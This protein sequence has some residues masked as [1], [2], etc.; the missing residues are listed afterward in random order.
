MAELSKQDGQCRGDNRRP[1]EA[2]ADRNLRDGLI[3]ALR[4]DIC[5]MPPEDKAT[6]E[7]IKFLRFVEKK[8]GDY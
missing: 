3:V 6:I 8:G 7:L 1:S 4:N 2:N 5:A